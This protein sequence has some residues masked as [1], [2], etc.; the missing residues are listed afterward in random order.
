MIRLSGVLLVIFLAS[1]SRSETPYKQFPME[2]QA[3]S[4][5]V[6]KCKNPSEMGWLREVIKKAE[7]DYQY[8][9]SIYAIPYHSETVF[10]HEP[11][12][13]DCFGCHVYDC[14]GE[15]LALTETEKSEILAS[16]KDEYVIYTSTQ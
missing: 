11:W 2:E 1:C 8:K 10:L 3:V 7:V 15:P 12:I 6:G 16:L 9:G 5:A 4:L 14:Q 13:N